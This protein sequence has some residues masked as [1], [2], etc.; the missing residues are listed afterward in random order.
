VPN[1][2]EEDRQIDQN[3]IIGMPRRSVLKGIAAISTVMSFGGTFDAINTM[4]SLDVAQR[5]LEKTH[6]QPPQEEADKA[7]TIVDRFDRCQESASDNCQKMLPLE[8]SVEIDN[9]K[10]IL[11]QEENFRKEARK[12]D[13]SYAPRLIVDLTTTGLGYVGVFKSVNKLID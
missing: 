11:R 2:K 1:N 5:E 12:L 3:K 9:A 10:Y 8:K 13:R 7:R 6:P 4:K